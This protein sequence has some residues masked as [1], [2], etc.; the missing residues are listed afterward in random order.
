MT[1]RCQI[2]CRIPR[3]PCEQLPYL[4]EHLR[5]SRIWQ[6]DKSE[7][8]LLTLPYKYFLSWHSSSTLSFYTFPILSS[9]RRHRWKTQ[10][11]RR[12][13]SPSDSSSPPSLP[14]FRKKWPSTS[15]SLRSIP[16]HL[17]S[18]YCTF[19]F[20]RCYSLGVSSLS[21]LCFPNIQT[22]RN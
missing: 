6:T 3:L 20:L 14:P 13:S 21:F 5:I 10:E 12:G 1:R 11:L 7:L 19:D 16:H 9:W 17:P 15:S 2:I 18:F 4:S 22:F 8:P